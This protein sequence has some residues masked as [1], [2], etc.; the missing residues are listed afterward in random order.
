MLLSSPA[1]TSEFESSL[2]TRIQGSIGESDFV[3]PL[4]TSLAPSVLGVAE[5]TSY[6]PLIPWS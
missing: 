5:V 6:G 2:Y 3:G 4:S 1:L